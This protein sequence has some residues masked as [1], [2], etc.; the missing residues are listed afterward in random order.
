MFHYVTCARLLNYPDAEGDAGRT[1]VPEVA[2]DFPTVSDGGRT[3]TFRIR[4]GFRF[5]PPSNEEVTAESFRHAIERAVKLTK[6]F[7]DDLRPPLDNVVGAQAYYAGKA[8]H[9]SGVSARDDELVLRFR[10]PEPDLP[11][12]VAASSCAVPVRTPVVKGGLEKPVPS[13]GPY[14]LATL[15]DSLAVLRRNPNY[16]GSRPQHLDAIVIEFNVPP[17]EAATRIENGTLDYFF[18]SQQATLTP[19]TQAARAARQSLSR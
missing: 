3:F 11:W 4:K 7:G 2:E 5:S 15:T 12:L 6:L 19:D 8:P 14:Y 1:L 9:I 13:A 17:A 18:E 16:G 10:E